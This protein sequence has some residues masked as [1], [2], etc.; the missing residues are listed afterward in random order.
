MPDEL[1]ELLARHGAL[2]EENKVLRARLREVLE[3][4]CKRLDGTNAELRQRLDLL[5]PKDDPG[6]NANL[7]TGLAD[8]LV[9]SPYAPAFR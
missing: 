7:A 4:E 9:N 2:A 6:G 5:V 1:P 3:R 8:A